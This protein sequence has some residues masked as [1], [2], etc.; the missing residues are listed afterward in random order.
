MVQQKHGVPHYY[1]LMEFWAE[2]Q[3]ASYKSL[4]IKLLKNGRKK[5]ILDGDKPGC[6]LPF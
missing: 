1:T 3:N 2:M 4:L 6:P 5:N